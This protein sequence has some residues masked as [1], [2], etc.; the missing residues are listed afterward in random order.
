MEIKAVRD[1]VITQ[2]KADP[3]VIATV[4]ASKIGK[5]IGKKVLS[6]MLPLS[7]R[8]VQLGRGEN[9]QDAEVL[10][11]ILGN[12]NVSVWEMYRFHV[13]GVFQLADGE[14]E[15]D[16]EDIES[17]LDRII[18]KAL[19]T[20]Y[21]LNDVVSEIILGRTVFRN[22]PE[23]DST[24]FVIVEVAAKVHVGGECPLM[25]RITSEGSKTVI[26]CSCGFKIYEEPVLRV[27]VALIRDGYFCPKCPQCKRFED[28]I[29]LDVFKGGQDG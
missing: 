9:S 28:S 17:N 13:V 16:A 15:E 14:T 6:S 27:R 29:S 1:A 22:L 4:G 10:D 23:E 24:Y 11:E 18:R 12:G 20:D 19:T 8:V 2:L 21:S 5:G 3:D 7:I 26:R 25:L